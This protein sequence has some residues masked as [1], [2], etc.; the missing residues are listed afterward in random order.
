[1]E[2]GMT[3]VAIGVVVVNWTGW[4][5]PI[6]CLEALARATPRP[7]CAVVVD[8]G[9]TDDSVEGLQRWATTR[10][11]LRVSIVAAGANR[12]FSAGNKLGIGQLARDARIS[13]FLL[14]KNHATGEP[15]FFSEPVRGLAPHP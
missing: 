4:R 2:A 13:P 14:L 8:N 3:P 10:D 5:D 12:G 15:T 11:A 6:A 7:E 9:S 1:M